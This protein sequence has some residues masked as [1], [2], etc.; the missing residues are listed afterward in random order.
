MTPEQEEVR[1]IGERLLSRLGHMQNQ[2]EK[3]ASCLEDIRV[4]HLALERRVGVL[5]G[6]SLNATKPPVQRAPWCFTCKDPSCGFVGR[7][8]R[9][10]ACAAWRDK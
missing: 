8:D 10:D 7:L 6:F 2:V 5:E 4:S 3:M 1:R 9:R